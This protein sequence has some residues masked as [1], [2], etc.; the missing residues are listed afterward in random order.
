MAGQVTCEVRAEPNLTPLLDIV[1]QLITFFMLVI[2][3]TS[4]NYDRRVHLP[5]AGSARPVE[6]TQQRLRGPACPER[7]QGRPSAGRRPGAAAQRG[8]R[9]H[10]APGRPGE[11]EPQGLGPQVR[12]GK[13]L[14]TMIVFRADKDS[15]FASV[16]SLLNACQTQ[17]F[18][19]F[20]LKA[21]T[22]RLDR[23]TIRCGNRSRPEDRRAQRADRAHAGH[24][25]SASDLLR[26]DLSPCPQEG[27]FVMSLLPRPARDRDG[28][29]PGR[30]PRP[31]RR[32][33]FRSRSARCPRP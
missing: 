25:L 33:T 29:R 7:R 9:D 19:K 18:R 4:D 30:R 1:F 28:R 12:S 5:V 8:H 13:G 11:A 14:P 20:A 15:T 17:G 6:D 22:E 10:Q 3:F 32:T 21:M 27:Q 24:G 2:N 26:A 23:D 31:P 16:M